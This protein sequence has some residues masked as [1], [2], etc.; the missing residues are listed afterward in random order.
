MFAEEA[1]QI[2]NTKCKSALAEFEAGRHIERY[3]DTA[4]HIMFGFLDASKLPERMSRN[5]L[6]YYTHIINHD[7]LWKS[8]PKRQ[9][10]ASLYTAMGPTSS[11]MSF[12]IFPYDGV[13]IGWCPDYDLWDSWPVLKSKN[14][15]SAN[16]FNDY[17]EALLMKAKADTSSDK[18]YGNFKKACKKFDIWFKKLSSETDFDMDEFVELVD[19]TGGRFHWFL[20]EYYKSDLYKAVSAVYNPKGF[21]VMTSKQQYLNSNDNEVWLDGPA[22]YVNNKVVDEWLSGDY[23]E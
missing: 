6:N 10:I 1:K 20:L 9:V 18:N 14:V 15:R 22:L 21:K 3:T 8:F 19:R 2:L 11:S 16:T 13:K 4:Q 5:T 17:I 12:I 7:P 23:E